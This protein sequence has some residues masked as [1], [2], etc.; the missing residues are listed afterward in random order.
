MHVEYPDF[1][2]KRLF[3]CTADAAPR[4][5]SPHK[6]ASLDGPRPCTAASAAESITP[7]A[8]FQLSHSLQ[9]DAVGNRNR[10]GGR[11]R[12]QHAQ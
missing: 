12:I 9:T 11:A 7:L 2:C 5:R 1:L 10:R 6:H 8:R 3:V 4:R